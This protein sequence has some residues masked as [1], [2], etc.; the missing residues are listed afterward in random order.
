MGAIRQNELVVRVRL[1]AVVVALAAGACGGDDDDSTLGSDGGQNTVPM[2]DAGQA[3]RHDAGPIAQ[4]PSNVA[5]AGTHGGCPPLK[6]HMSFTEFLASDDAWLAAARSRGGAYVD[7]GC[8]TILVQIPVWGISPTAPVVQ[9]PFRQTGLFDG[10][11]YA[12]DDSG[13]LYARWFRSD[14]LSDSSCE[15]NFVLCDKVTRCLLDWDYAKTGH[16]CQGEDDGG[17]ET[18]DAGSEDAGADLGQ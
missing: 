1:A 16:L 4:D 9:G 2:I 15:G 7:Q 12:F 13:D 17:T 11:G 3:P 6:K 10:A 5:D 18:E 8:G 14:Q